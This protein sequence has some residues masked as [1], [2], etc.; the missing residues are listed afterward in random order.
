MW[1]VCAG[2]SPIFKRSLRSMYINSSWKKSRMFNVSSSCHAA[3]NKINFLKIKR[4][5]SYFCPRVNFS[6]VQH[7]IIVYLSPS[8]EIIW[9]TFLI[10]TNVNIT[11]QLSD[12]RLFSVSNAEANHTG[13]LFN[14]LLAMASR[15]DGNVRRSYAEKRLS[16]SSLLSSIILFPRFPGNE[17][18]WSQGRINW[19]GYN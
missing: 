6:W 2:K 3:G 13:S 5:F 9:K 8:I 7:F 19:K 14:Y 12:N 15:C 11:E 10:W 17:I 18:K 1:D 4:N 16:K